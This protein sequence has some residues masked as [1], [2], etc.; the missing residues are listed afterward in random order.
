MQEAGDWVLRNNYRALVSV[1][2][3]ILLTENTIYMKIIM[4]APHVW[5]LRESRSAAQFPLTNREDVQAVLR[6]GGRF[7]A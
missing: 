6:R 3:N 5:E 4:C 1:N 7:H 2:T